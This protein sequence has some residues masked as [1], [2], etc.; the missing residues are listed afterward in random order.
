MRVSTPKIVESFFSSRP[1]DS[2]GR[3]VVCFGIAIVVLQAA[4]SVRQ[5]TISKERIARL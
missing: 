5:A 2:E 4:G 3:D 1:P